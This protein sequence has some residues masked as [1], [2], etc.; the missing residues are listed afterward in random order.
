MGLVGSWQ[1]GTGG[2]RQA[3]RSAERFG[4]S[5]VGLSIQDGASE[6][7]SNCHFVEEGEEQAQPW[8]WEWA[9]SKQLSFPSPRA[10]L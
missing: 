4:G 1:V 10:A 7:K 5:M 6:A 9:W 8:G 2:I 3:S